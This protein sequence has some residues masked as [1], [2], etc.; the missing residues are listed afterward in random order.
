MYYCRIHSCVSIV[1]N[2]ENEY[3][4]DVSRSACED[5]HK[6]GILKDTESLIVRE[7]KI[8]QTVEEIIVYD[9]PRHIMRVI[10]RR[11]TMLAG[12]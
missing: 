6:I 1:L 12:D 10:T 2:G 11:T 4:N 5:V 8:N 7:I 3:I 9:V